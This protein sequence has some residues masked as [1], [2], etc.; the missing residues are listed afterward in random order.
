MIC[1]NNVQ[2]T[3]LLGEISRSYLT[4]ELYFFIAAQIVHVAQPIVI[5]MGQATLA[6][7]PAVRKWHQSCRGNTYV[8]SSFL[9]MILHIFC[10]VQQECA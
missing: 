10:S 7:W 6:M 5:Q 1:Q 2:C 8:S 3:V 4:G 9:L